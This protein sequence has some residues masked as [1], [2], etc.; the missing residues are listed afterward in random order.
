MLSKKSQDERLDTEIKEES[1][2]CTD[3]TGQHSSLKVDDVKV[4]LHSLTPHYSRSEDD[5]GEVRFSQNVAEKAWL[6][7]QCEGKFPL[8]SSK[9]HIMSTTSGHK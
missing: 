3:L 6:F 8:V 9:E 5:L 1:Y 2:F 7:V 4:K